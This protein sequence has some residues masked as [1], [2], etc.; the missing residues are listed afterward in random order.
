MNEYLQNEMKNLFIRALHYAK[1]ANRILTKPTPPEVDYAAVACCANAAYANANAARVIYF[2]EFS[3][4][5]D[6][7]TE[8]V[9]SQ[10]DIFMKEVTKAIETKSRMHLDSEIDML[11]DAYEK[12]YDEF[13]EDSDE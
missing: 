9:L 8:D 13:P 10:F 4:N 3:G 5:R 12:N 7:G 1:A 2:M 11:Q 6:K